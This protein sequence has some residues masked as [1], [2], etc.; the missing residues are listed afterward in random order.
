[1]IKFADDYYTI[2]V[3]LFIILYYTSWVSKLSI[4]LINY[5]FIIEWELLNIISIQPS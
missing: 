1:M 4:K 3:V 2:I 5:L